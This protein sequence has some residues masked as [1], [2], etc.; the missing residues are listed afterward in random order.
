[1]T[2]SKSTAPPVAPRRRPSKDK[3]ERASAK[4][5]T[6]CGHPFG[7]AEMK[8]T[9]CDE[10]CRHGGPIK[11]GRYVSDSLEGGQK[12]A[13]ELAKLRPGEVMAAGRGKGKG[14]RCALC[15]RLGIE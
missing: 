11:V 4:R 8:W 3:G 2:P 5:C 10:K 15:E 12:S 7:E 6:A 9:P 13:G 14:A 1:M